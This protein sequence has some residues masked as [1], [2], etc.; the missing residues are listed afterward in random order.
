MPAVAPATPA[1]DDLVF[2]NLDR[3]GFRQV[4]DL[5]SASK[6]PTVQ[7]LVAVRAQKGKAG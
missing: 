3:L 6:R 2:D 7:V 5:T 4:D 1:F